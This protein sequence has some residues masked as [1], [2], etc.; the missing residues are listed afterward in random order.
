MYGVGMGITSC[1]YIF[2]FNT[3]TCTWKTR[4]ERLYIFGFS[5]TSLYFF[6]NTNLII[7][8]GNWKDF[9]HSVSL[10]FL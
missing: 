4:L 6:I 10:L 7:D 1:Q 2:N 5:I 8:W 9:R 3:F